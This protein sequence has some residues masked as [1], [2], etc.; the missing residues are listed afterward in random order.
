MS[1]NSNRCQLQRLLFIDRMIR[2]GMQ[3]G[4]LAN[5][6]TIAAAYEVSTKSI[7]RD[8]DYLKNQA[9]APIKYIRQRHG[10][11][12]T[13]ESYQLPAIQIS[14]S[15]LFAIA[16]ARKTLRQYENTPLYQK[17]VK[18]FKKIEES[19]PEKVSVDPAWVDERMSVVPESRTIIN[20]A[21]WESIAEGLRRNKR[22]EI[23]YHKPGSE[24]AEPRLVDPY[25]TVSFQG[26]WYLIGHCH[27]RREIRTFALSR[28]RT[29]QVTSEGFTPPADFSFEQYSGHQFGIFQGDRERLVLLLFSPHHRPY[30]EEREWHREQ[31]LEIR[32]DGSL[33]L[34]FPT[35]HL[36]EV[37]RWVLSWGEGVKVLA[38]PE[39]ADQLRKEIRKTLQA[40]EE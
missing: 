39:L 15:D 17:L 24:C 2:E 38:P 19:L 20:P 40:Y 1:S 14:E 5:C 9:G 31:Q 16:L 4:R 26:E 11:C 8:I 36:F 10:F 13:E 25:H 28:I 3:S 18:V 21:V 23:R 29:A 30:V 35:K 22:L 34:S 32:K 7:L 37:K 12:Y 33:L 27:R 6:A